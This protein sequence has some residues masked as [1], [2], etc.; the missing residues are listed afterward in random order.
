MF[1]AI[2]ALVAEVSVTANLSQREPKGLCVQQ[3]RH[4]PD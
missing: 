2:S 1:R 3:A 4:L